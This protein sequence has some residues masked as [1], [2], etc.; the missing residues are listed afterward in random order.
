M[1]RP[2]ARCCAADHDTP[3]KTAARCDAQDPLRTLRDLFMLPEGVIYLDGNS[4]GVLPKAAAGARRA[5]RAAGMG[6][7]PDPLLEQRRL[8]RAAAAP[9]RQDR[10]A[11]RRRRRAKWWR[12]TAPRSTSTR[13]SAPRCASRAADA[14]ERSVVVSERSNFPT[15]LYI[16]EALCTRA[17]LRSCSWST[18]ERHRG[19]AGADDVAV[20]MLTHVN[21]RTGA[22][23]DMAALTASGARAPARWRCGTWRTAPA[24]CRWTCTAPTPTSR[25]A[26]ATS[27]STAAPARRPSCGCIRATPDRFWQPLAGWWGHAAPF[28]FTPDYRPAPGIARYLCG[29]QP[30]LSMAALECGLDTVLRR[31]SR[32]AA[33]R[34]CAPSRWR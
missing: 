5:G 26:A 29:T 21:Y 20:L 32:W 34:R 16:A 22:M 17:R 9:G 28:E 15:D 6:P 30:I 12:P 19:R 4:L 14:P 33:W 3:C 25:S 2:C 18:A 13:C 1:P 10:A 7:G 11:G 27:T 31:A 24:R 8:V 23:H